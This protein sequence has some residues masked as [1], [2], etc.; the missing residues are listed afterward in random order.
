M[1][2]TTQ[3]LLCCKT[4]SGTSSKR[5]EDGSI[6]E[7][8]IINLSNSIAIKENSI[9]IELPSNWY[10]SKWVGFALWAPVY[11]SAFEQLESSV[12][13]AHVIAL[14]DM[15]QNLWDFG[16]LTTLIYGKDQICLLY[17]FRDKWFATVGN[18]KCSR[19]KVTFEMDKSPIFLRDCGVS[20]I[21]EQDVDE[22][23]QKN[24]QSLIESF[25]ENV[26]IYKLAG[27]DHLK[28]PSH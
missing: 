15:P 21:Y 17:L 26:S 12:F 28:H 24:A 27:N 20:L 6:T 1:G 14:G 8:Q 4:V 19:I 16:L 23:N 18:G 5:E 13:G 11:L 9:F 22:F 25:G 10:N 3:G 7:F 2:T